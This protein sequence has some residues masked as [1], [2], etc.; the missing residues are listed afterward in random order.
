MSAEAAPHSQSCDSLGFLFC[1]M[2]ALSVSYCLQAHL[3]AC[4]ATKDVASDEGLTACTTRTA[5][6]VAAM[7]QVHGRVE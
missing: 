2:C 7:V 5:K 6:V 1:D 4:C 3:S